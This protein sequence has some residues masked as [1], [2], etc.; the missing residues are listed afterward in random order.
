MKGREKTLLL[1]IVTFCFLSADSNAAKPAAALPQKKGTKSIMVNVYRYTDDVISMDYILPEPEVTVLDETV[2]GTNQERVTIG[3]AI[4]QENE[5]E[6]VLP[7]VP[8]QFIIP[9]G[10][11]IDK[12]KVIRGKAVKLAGKHMIEHGR[13]PIPLMQNIKVR[14]AV[15]NPIIY[16]SDKPFPDKAYELVS[17]Q[18]KRGVAIAIINLYPATYYPK[19]GRL[20]Y[21]KTISLQVTTKPDTKTYKLRTRPDD[22]F[23][24]KMGL[25]NPEVVMRAKSKAPAKQI[26]RRHFVPQ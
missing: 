18:R 9:P 19:S 10:K 4:L 5:G 16:N 17:I 15:Q 24:L 22:T 6:P 12:I 1:A 2:G 20:Y 3:N 8:S 14:K 21:C 11:T 13:A 26:A 25:E 7:V 23:L